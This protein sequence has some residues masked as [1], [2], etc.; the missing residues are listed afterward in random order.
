MQYYIFLILLLHNIFVVLSNQFY[1]DIKQLILI[2]ILLVIS[3]AFV[4]IKYLYTNDI[5]F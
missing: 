5:K 4:F 2:V 3:K 1:N